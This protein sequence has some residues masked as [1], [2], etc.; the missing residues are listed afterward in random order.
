MVEE[1][2]YDEFVERSVELAKN[3]PVGNP[4]DVNVQQG[5]QVDQEQHAKILSY[6]KSGKEQGAKLL[7]GGD[8]FGNK[9]YFVQVRTNILIYIVQMENVKFM[10]KHTLVK[11]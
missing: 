8:K 1:S 3:R 10:H 6:I 7:T 9:G 4:F 11:Y 5:P 2:V